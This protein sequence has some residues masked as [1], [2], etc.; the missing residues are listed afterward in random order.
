MKF[1]E[2][3]EGI[4][5][6]YK[7]VPDDWEEKEL[8]ERDLTTSGRKLLSTGLTKEQYEEIFGKKDNKINK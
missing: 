5:T 4:K 8:P 1:I 2:K 6:I 3:K 7:W